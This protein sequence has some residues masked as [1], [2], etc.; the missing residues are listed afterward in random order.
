[1]GAASCPTAREGR[2]APG[3]GKALFAAT[4]ASLGRLPIVAEDLGS[5]TPGTAVGN[6]SWRFDRDMVSAEVAP[7]LARLVLITGRSGPVA[8]RPVPG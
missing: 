4:L 2:W 7:R 1:M 6:W 3:P 5:I 8:A